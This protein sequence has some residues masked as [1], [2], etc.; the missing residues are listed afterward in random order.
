MRGEI[1][2][3]PFSTYSVGEKRPSA[4]V[5]SP[6]RNYTIPVL[7]VIATISAVAITFGPGQV[8][9]KPFA[10]VGHPRA[11]D[12]YKGPSGEGSEGALPGFDWRLGNL[13]LPSAS[14]SRQVPASP[15]KQRSPARPR[16][17]IGVQRNT[18][19]VEPSPGLRNGLPEGI[20][21]P[22]L[23][24]GLADNTV[25]ALV[26][27]SP[28]CAAVGS[29][30]MEADPTSSAIHETAADSASSARAAEVLEDSSG[31]E[32]IASERQP[33]LAD[34]N[35]G[36]IVQA[37]VGS[38]AV[39][40]A[41]A[42]LDPAVEKP[43]D[44]IDEK[45]RDFADASKNTQPFAEL[46][47]GVRAATSPKTTPE[48]DVATPADGEPV[49]ALST[50]LARIKERYDDTPRKALGTQ[51]EKDA[52]TAPD[53][54]VDASLSGAPLTQ[55][56]GSTIIVQD[57]ELVAIKLSE[58]IS[59]FESRL[60]RPLFVWMRTASAASKFV[61]TDTLASAGIRAQYDSG[62]RRLIL[63]LSSE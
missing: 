45:P 2:A 44:G 31:S 58:L 52:G 20:A 47:S 51:T 18:A 33:L 46:S 14:S 8:G 27:C 60:E 41:A 57:N 40:A 48:I 56:L 34:Y 5:C 38:S 9:E 39:R 36:R 32:L 37:V 25:V 49:T 50:H 7:A 30:T 61:T 4:R 26:D 1:L 21:D 3:Y 11:S 19:L 54:F 53:A 43:I 16:V 63:S 24:T 62:S 6:D 23:L 42:S 12:R 59:L 28:V 22:P 17:T 35:H 29:A 15:A 13:Q 10:P 55:K